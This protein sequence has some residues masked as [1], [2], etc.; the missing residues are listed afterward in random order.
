MEQ[1]GNSTSDQKKS[2]SNSNNSSVQTTDRWIKCIAKSGSIT[3]TAII[4]PQ[5]VEEAQKRHDLGPKETKSLGEVM[6]ASLLLVSSCKEGERLSLSVRGEGQL[7]QSVVDANP[8]GTVR[9]FILS[10]NQFI[11]PNPKKGPWQNGFLTVVRLKQNQKEPYNGT[12]QLLTGHL[13]KDITFYLSQS[14]QIPAAVGLAVDVDEKNKIKTAGA[15]IVQIL[16]GAS[17]EEIALIEKNINTM[18]ELAEQVVR[19][20]NPT[21]LLS[22]VFNDMTFTIL[23]E[24]QVRFECHCQKDKVMTALRML[25]KEELLD[26]I[27]KDKG[28]DVKC[29]FCSKKYRFEIDELAKLVREKMHE[30]DS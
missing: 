9:G 25:G 3:A 23:D 26:M 1:S 22:Q 8:N 27:D 10:R 5:I 14:E 6:L 11:E 16:P 29:D 20:S 24:K 17:D 12:V 2:S 4:A 28:A 19:T 30:N 13:A 21:L 15:F 18:E 7:Q